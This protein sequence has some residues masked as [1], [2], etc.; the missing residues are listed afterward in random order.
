METQTSL[1][2]NKFRLTN[3]KTNRAMNNSLHGTPE[4]TKFGNCFGASTLYEYNAFLADTCRNSSF[5]TTVF[6]PT[7]L[8]G[9]ISI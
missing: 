2:F 5:R 7:L 3:N 8:N 6:N 4:R 1:N 9:Y